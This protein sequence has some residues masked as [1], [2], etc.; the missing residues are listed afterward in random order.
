MTLHNKGYNVVSGASNILVFK[1]EATRDELAAAK[2]VEA[3]RY[4]NPVDGTIASTG[5]FASPTGFVNHDSPIPLEELEQHR[6]ASAASSSKAANKTFLDAPRPSNKVR[7]EEAVFSG[8]RRG[9]WQ[10]TKGRRCKRKTLPT[11]MMTFAYIVC[12]GILTAT[13]C[14]Q[15]GVVCELMSR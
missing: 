5:N 1:K 15:I 3:K 11:R 8:R 10:E 14:Y 9:G 7:R 4:P 13:T 6:A 12:T 2:H